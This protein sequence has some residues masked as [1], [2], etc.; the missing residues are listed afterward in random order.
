MRQKEREFLRTNPQTSCTRNTFLMQVFGSV[1]ASASAFGMMK[2]TLSCDNS[3][4]S[5][6]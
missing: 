3:T 6:E 4:E 1:K 5:T 2:E